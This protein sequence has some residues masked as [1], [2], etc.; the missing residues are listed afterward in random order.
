[1]QLSATLCSIKRSIN[2]WMSLQLKLFEAAPLVHRVVILTKFGNISGAYSVLEKLACHWM[3]FHNLIHVIN[4]SFNYRQGKIG[5]NYTKCFSWWLIKIDL[6]KV[7]MFWSFK[8][9][10]FILN[11]QIKLGLQFLVETGF[12]RKEGNLLPWRFRWGSKI[13][14]KETQDK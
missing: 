4:V 14:S 12:V 1:M 11:F 9:C 6:F 13:S 5:P 8:T 3:I 2:V 7:W 10:V